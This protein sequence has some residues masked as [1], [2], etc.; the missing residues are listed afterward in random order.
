MKD[1][2][3]VQDWIR[4]QMREKNQGPDQKLDE[5]EEPGSGLGVRGRR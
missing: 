1:K 3:Q 4:S 2:N 5:R